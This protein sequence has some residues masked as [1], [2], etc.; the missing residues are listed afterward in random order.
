MHQVSSFHK[1]LIVSVVG[2]G[3]M[4]SLLFSS[5]LL[6][7]H[8]SVSDGSSVFMV[9]VEREGASSASPLPL[10]QRATET[11][12]QFSAAHT[13]ASKDASQAV[14]PFSFSLPPKP[15]E[16]AM[17]IPGKTVL[18][19]PPSALQK[20]NQPPREKIAP[21]NTLE[22]E[23]IT[24][25]PA[26]GVAYEGAQAG[27]AG[28]FAHNASPAYFRNPPPHYPDSAR[29]LRQEGVVRL[30]VL[31]DTSGHAEEVTVIHSS[32]YE[33]LDSSAL[34]AV[35]GWQFKPGSIDGAAVISRVDVPIRFSL[36]GR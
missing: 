9:T 31:V 11:S 15:F 30:S 12:G 26:N 10:E 18:H 33:A 34:N 17:P 8:T 25:Q 23:H 1:A 36:S 7:P 21:A 14:L 28:G 29:R 27:T 35:K 3:S 32:G 5:V 24:S 19:S 6:S 4:A 16:A 2:H 20:R 13:H 22:Q